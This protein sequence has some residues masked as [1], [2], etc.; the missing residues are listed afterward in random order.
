MPV[1]QVTLE[2]LARG[3]TGQDDADDVG[4]SRLVLIGFS[5]AGK[6]TVGQQLATR[7]GWQLLDLDERIEAHYGM[8]IPTVFRHH[9]E[10]H[11]RLTERRLLIEALG[12]SGQVI[13]TGGGAVASDEV[14][15]DGFLTNPDVLVVA[16]DVQPETTLARLRAQQAASGDR[17]ARPM[18]AGDDPLARMASLKAARQEAYDRA[19]VTIMTDSV[20]ATGVVEEAY[21]LQAIA[22]GARQE[23]SLTAGAR[24][25]RIVVGEGLLADAGGLVRATYPTAARIWL[26]SD[27]HVGPLHGRELAAN[28]SEAGFRVERRD[29]PSGEGSKGLATAGELFDWLLGG[30]IER[31]DVVMALGG[32][33]IG[34]LAGFVAATTLRGV[35]LV[36]VPTSL[37]AMVD[38]SVG[39]KT[40]INHP[41]GKNLIGAFYQPPLV[42]IDPLLLGTLP[43]REL[44]SGWAEIVK[45][46]VIQPSTP[47]GERSDLW[48]YL[49]RNAPALLSRRQPALSYLIAR[50]V[51][52]KAA[53]VEAD[54]REAS[55]RQILNFGHTLG[56]GIEAAGYRYLHGEA[57]ALG[58]RAAA[59]IGMAVGTCDAALVGRLDATLDR[60][61]LPAH[62]TADLDQVL[63]LMRGDKKRTAGVQRW[64]L[65]LT[66]GG[67]EIRSNVPD[68]VVRRCLDEISSPGPGT[69][70]SP[71]PRE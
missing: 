67:V 13:V 46:A 20:S 69:G 5:G 26:I 11:F 36:Q 14:W 63:Q 39:G 66:G 45:H 12:Q 9:G 24:N 71:S 41:T 10:P 32:G 29:V 70:S 22:R 52:L 64:V 47:G 34:D 55:L 17:V 53:V 2:P 15:T 50:N 48:T 25:S 43:R 3:A 35:G 19:N 30:G 8:D 4:P 33:V 21:R 68:H 51:A 65:P 60:F 54:E 16:L 58:M 38:S 37:L 56:H 7:L 1:V 6:T 42:L 40:G 49:D 44:A 61:G 27:E 57:V 31:G 18:L 62:S 23:I 28:L 59:R